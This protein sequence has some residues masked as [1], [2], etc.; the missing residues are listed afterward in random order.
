MTQDG[1][2]HVIQ[3]QDAVW[4]AM[5]EQWVIPLQCGNFTFFGPPPFPVEWTVLHSFT[6]KNTSLRTFHICT[7][8]HVSLLLFF[9]PV[10]MKS[11]IMMAD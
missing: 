5:T 4:D 8:A 6:F 1:D 11:H 10:P 7:T 3:K 2:L 9:F